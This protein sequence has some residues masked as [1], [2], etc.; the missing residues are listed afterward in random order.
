MTQE[1]T[2]EINNSVS[3]T[4]ALAQLNLVVGDIHG[5][6]RQILKAAREARDELHADLVI[7]PELT[8]TGYP[9]ED[10][11]LRPGL[12]RQ[13]ATALAWLQREIRGID[14]LIGY[15]HQEGGKLY[16][17]CAL[18][19]DGRIVARYDKQ[20][21]PN[22]GVFDEKRYFVPGE[23]PCRVQIRDIPVAL[24]ICE[25]IWSEGPARQAR[26]AG[27]QLI[28]NINASPFHGG[29]SD[30]REQLL[31]QRAREANMPIAYVN[32]VGGQDELVFDGHS[33]VVDAAGEVA[34]R[35]PS[36]ESGLHVVRFQATGAGLHPL[37]ATLA[38]V[39][40][41]MENAYQAL[42]TGVRDYVHKNHFKGAVIG[43]SGG[44]DSALTLAIA[45]D[46]LGADAVEAISMPSRYTAD[47]SIEDARLEAEALGIGFRVIPIE[48]VFNAFLDSL[49]EAFAETEADTTEENLQAR[50]RG[51]LLMAV[52]NKHGKLVLTTGNKS[53]VAV[54]YATL[55]GDMAGGFA[56][57]KDVEKM[58]VYRLSAWRNTVS[59]VIP[60]R[61]L[62]R[63]P[64]AELRP[65]QVDQDSLPPYPELDT[66][67]KLFVEQDQ[68]PDEIVAQGYSRE[69]VE[70]IA[71]MVLRNE[72]KRRQAAPGVRITQRAFGRDRRYPITS[73]YRQH[74]R[75]ETSDEKD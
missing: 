24:T 49:E 71:G 33:L 72:Y 43:L 32:L 51:V 50:T 6:T 37:P 4:I 41:P 2:P 7:F 64:S 26:D 19:R 40:T 27:A 59:P 57:L 47:M 48:P 61:V 15:P 73:G 56:P 31:A 55:Y 18:L 23:S 12:H 66:I 30:E 10:L 16:N 17:A 11:L 28:I 29:K 14:L 9:P 68:S 53:E 54:G 39:G 25:D 8:L 20:S 38:D 70:R 3:L 69:T 36:F 1:Q 75:M 67:L 45:V 34:L 65:D 13:V 62:D 5:N 42:V 74:E 52:S 35:A 63:P 21:L 22:Y 46:A 60:Q 44:I 58:E